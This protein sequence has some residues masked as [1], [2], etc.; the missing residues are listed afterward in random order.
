[1]FN[2]NMLIS[3]KNVKLKTLKEKFKLISIHHYQV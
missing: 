3:K 2:A 1:M